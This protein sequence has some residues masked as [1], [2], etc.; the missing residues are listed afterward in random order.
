MLD[1]GSLALL[2]QH[3]ERLMGAIQNRVEHVKAQIL[4]PVHL[5]GKHADKI[6]HS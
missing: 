4:S 2:G 3:F 1:P 6:I 5:Y